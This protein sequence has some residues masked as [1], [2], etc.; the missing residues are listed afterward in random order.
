[1]GIDDLFWRS[2]VWAARKPFVVR[3]YPRLW[4]VQMDDTLQGW[5]PRVRDMYD[6]SLTGRWRGRDRGPWRITGNVFTNNV[7]P[8]SADRASMIADINAGFLQVSPH[9]RGP[10]YGDIYWKQ[11]RASR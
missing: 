6:V 2:L 1:M 5:G 3:G 11:R 8:G 4:T 9:A 7:A 10:S